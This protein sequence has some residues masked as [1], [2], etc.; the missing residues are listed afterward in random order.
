MSEKKAS[1]IIS[2]LLAYMYIVALFE[3]SNDSNI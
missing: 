3:I 2:D 1:I